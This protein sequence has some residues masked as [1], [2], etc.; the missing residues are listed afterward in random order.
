MTA[1]RK[2]LA[3]AVATAALSLPAF[4]VERAEAVQSIDVTVDMTGVQNAAAAAYWGTLEK[5]LEAAVLSRVAD[6]MAEEG[7][8]I[9]VDIDEVSLASGFA[10]AVGLGESRLSGLVKVSDPPQP[11]RGASY[12][13]SV[14]MNATLPALGEGFDLNTESLDTA[15]V[16]HAMVDTFAAQIVANLDK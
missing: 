8:M 14:D 3:A 16:Y 12:E 13:L 10:E 4:A 7:A 2:T 1:F 6:R 11:G 9:T 5:D 15:R